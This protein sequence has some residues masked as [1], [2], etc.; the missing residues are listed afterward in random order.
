MGLHARQRY[1]PLYNFKIE[2]T[3]CVILI[4]LCPE[5]LNEENR[6]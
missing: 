5:Q 3:I 2:G 4:N 1:S 6:A